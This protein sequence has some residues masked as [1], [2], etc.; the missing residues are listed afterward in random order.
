MVFLALTVGVELNVDGLGES[1]VSH[2]FICIRHFQNLSI[3]LLLSGVNANRAVILA[4]QVFI[5][6]FAAFII[7]GELVNC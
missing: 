7:L 1:Q 2:V 3:H 5:V 6:K 4:L